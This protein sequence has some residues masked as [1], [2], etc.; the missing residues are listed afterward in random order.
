ML[1]PA[2]LPYRHKGE[3]MFFQNKQNLTT[4]KELQRIFKEILHS[5]I[6]ENSPHESANS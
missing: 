4:R 2:S 1:D 5:E 6:K 3:I